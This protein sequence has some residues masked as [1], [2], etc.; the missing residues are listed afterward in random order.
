VLARFLFDAWFNDGYLHHREG[1]IFP[2]K[3][4]AELAD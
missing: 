4:I 3:F 2:D 1:I